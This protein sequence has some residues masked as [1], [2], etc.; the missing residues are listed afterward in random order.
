MC[1]KINGLG[2]DP[3]AIPNNLDAEKQYLASKG[4]DTT[5]MDEAG[6][7]AKAQELRQ[8]DSVPNSVVAG[9]DPNKEPK[10]AVD[11]GGSVF[12]KIEGAKGPSVTVTDNENHEITFDNYTSDKKFDRYLARNGFNDDQIDEILAEKDP[13]KVQAKLKAGLDAHGEKK[14]SGTLVLDKDR[15]AKLQPFKEEKPLENSP[16]KALKNRFSKEEYPDLYNKKGE[17]KTNKAWK[18][19]ENQRFIEL[20]FG[21][22]SEKARI[23]EFVDQGMLLAQAKKNVKAQNESILKQEKF[24]QNKKLNGET[25]TE[26][27]Q[28]F[29]TLRER[30][31][32]DAKNIKKF[33][34]NVEKVT[35]RINEAIDKMNKWDWNKDLNASQKEKIRKAVKNYEV[36]QN[37]PNLYNNMF[38]ESGNLKNEKKNMLYQFVM[39]RVTG[40]DAQVNKSAKKGGFF[41]KIFKKQNEEYTEK[42]ASRDLGLN[43]KDIENMGFAWENQINWGKVM[44]DGVAPALLGAA[45]GAAVADKD[46]GF[47]TDSKTANA[48]AVATV[49][50]QTIRESKPYSGSVDYKVNGETVMQIPYDGVVDFVKEI[51]GKTVTATDSQTAV[52]NA[53][54]TASVSAVLPAAIIAGTTAMVHSMYDQGVNGQEKDIFRGHLIR[55]IQTSTSKTELK[56]PDDVLKACGMKNSKNNQQYQLAREILSYYYDEKGTLHTTE[57]EAD[58]KYNAG[59]K[60]E[61][62]NMEEGAMWLDQL[63]KKG[64]IRSVDN[65]VKVTIPPEV[66]NA[67]YH[68][69]QGNGDLYN[70]NGEV[71]KIDGYNAVGSSAEARDTKTMNRNKVNPKETL[72]EQLQKQPTNKAQYA[73][74]YVD[75]AKHPDT[76]KINAKPQVNPDGSKNFLQPEEITFVDSTNGKLHTY[77]FKLVTDTSKYPKLSHE[78]GP[79]YQVISGV[80]EQGKNILNPKKHVEIFRLNAEQQVAKEMR[81]QDDKG[82]LINA[83]ILHYDYNMIQDSENYPGYGVSM[84]NNNLID[85]F[86]PKPKKK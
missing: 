61:Y 1:A 36:D 66:I 5:N 53:S 78:Q 16:K 21:D 52:A 41:A 54:A 20:K 84:V 80:D 15:Y 79:F 62:L 34:K 59:Y 25:L 12:N 67:I 32:D 48:N 44:T 73:V 63:K 19:F 42:A 51:A 39:D 38:D 76:V 40:T 3:K 64:R 81:F 56:T 57:L 55:T 10:K 11:K 27:E 69:I 58:W 77:T 4:V 33:S 43:K 22:K 65:K 35:E 29:V 13:E 83:Q 72:A 70:S 24:A 50:G 82:A 2:Q 17:L 28:E 75:K 85:P 18:E 47:A 68:D 46:R 9:D 71:T 60:S 45:F 31:H 37:I 49:D 30:A 26:A 7:R 14:K 6:I 86:N 23:Q 8:Q 74:S